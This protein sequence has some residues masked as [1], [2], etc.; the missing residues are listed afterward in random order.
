[1]LEPEP[2]RQIERTYVLWRNRKLSYF[3]GCDYFRLS[4]H[5]RVGQALVEGLSKF[6]LTVAAS[7]LTTGNHALYGRLERRLARFFKADTA[8]LVSSGYLSNLVVAQALAGQFSHAL[9]NSAAHPSLI[10]AAKFL[11]CPILR[12]RHEMGTEDLAN[13]IDRCGQGAKLILLTDGMLTNNGSVAPLKEYLRLL[14]RDATMLVDDAHGAGVLGA[15]GRGSLEHTA[16]D[17]KQVVQTM[18]LSKAFGAYGGAILGSKH[19]RTRMLQRSQLF[20]GSTPLPLP[21]ANAALAALDILETDQ[22]L[23]SRLRS[24]TLQVKNVLNRSGLVLPKN[25]G[26]IIA[27][28]PGNSSDAPAIKRALLAGGIYPPLIQYPGAPTGGYFRFVISSEHS[29]E[30]LQSLADVLARNAKR[31]VGA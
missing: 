6:G 25:P 31:I 28:K 9:L 11:D 18:S 20:L 14:P 23:R 4:S 26:P 3:S 12:F 10:D 7:R 24:N 22:S 1:M 29:R 17:R 21:L 27:L 8:L 16:I 5:P 2:L 13:V 30:Q 19:L 15:H